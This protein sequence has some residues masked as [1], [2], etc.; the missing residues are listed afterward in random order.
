MAQEPDA[1]MHQ[2][3]FP[4]LQAPRLLLRDWRPEDAAP[5]AALN[6]D[7]EVTRHLL[8]PFSR[9]QSDAQIES[10]RAHFRQHGF[11][12]WAIEVPGEADLAGMVGISVIP[13][14]A[15][16]T[17]A[18]EVAWRLARPFWGRGF[19]SEA[20][21]AAIAFGFAQAGLA[22]IVAQTVPVNTRS[23]AVMERLGMR[24]DLADDFDHPLLPDGHALKRHVLYRIRPGDLPAP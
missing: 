24:R 4:V 16:F 17:P 21:R 12:R 23:R 1:P 14:A 5:F 2:E 7:A 10:F 3:P 6:A 9:A 15:H 8:G 18:V 13:Y 22:E 19:A 20:A 11:G